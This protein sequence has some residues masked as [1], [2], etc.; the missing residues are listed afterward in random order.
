MQII[1]NSVYISSDDVNGWTRARTLIPSQH[2]RWT[3]YGR[4][5]RWRWRWWWKAC[6]C[7]HKEWWTMF[8]LCVFHLE[9]WKNFSSGPINSVYSSVNLKWALGWENAK[10][11]RS[12]YFGW[13][14]KILITSFIIQWIV[15]FDTVDGSY[16]HGLWSMQIMMIKLTTKIMFQFVI[17]IHY[18]RQPGIHTHTPKYLSSML[19]NLLFI[20]FCFCEIRT[21]YTYSLA[22]MMSEW[23][24]IEKRMGRTQTSDSN[25]VFSWYAC[26]SIKSAIT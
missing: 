25:E 26:N 14:R 24:V 17:S 1:I 11:E 19:K 20:E 15:R 23:N 6:S 22:A 21:N 12:I 13:H 8:N 10:K 2:S 4:V 7:V 16:T 3:K 9:R 18:I 5:F